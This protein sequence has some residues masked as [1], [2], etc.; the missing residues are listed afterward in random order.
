MPTRLCDTGTQLQL[1]LG[2]FPNAPF[3]RTLVRLPSIRFQES[4]RFG[5]V[6]RYATAL[7]TL[8]AF[9]LAMSRYLDFLNLNNSV[10]R[11]LV[12][13]KWQA[14]VHHRLEIVSNRAP[15][16]QAMRELGR[17][18]DEAFHCRPKR[19]CTFIPSE[20]L[21][22]R[23]TILHHNLEELDQSDRLWGIEQWC[24]IRIRIR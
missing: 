5:R 11:R 18:V 8:N 15:N 22:A 23:R 13:K 20:L 10:L 9:H 4:P 6:R 1:D 2:P 16:R 7:P 19:I 24:L 3:D 21:D 14:F 12:T 17:H